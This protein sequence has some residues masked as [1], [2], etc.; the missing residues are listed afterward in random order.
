MEL[1]K[2][3][4]ATPAQAGAEMQCMSPDGK[5][6]LDC[7]ITFVGADSKTWRGLVKAARKKVLSGE[8][9]E[10]DNSIE[11]SKAALSWRGFTQDGE[12]VE[13]S[14]DALV[15][16]FKSAPYLEGQADRFIANRVNFTKE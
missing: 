9:E 3:D 7:F 14:K 2:L 11:L 1:S 13:F 4:T 10:V 6:K 16:L 8:S 5:E 15:A 12:E